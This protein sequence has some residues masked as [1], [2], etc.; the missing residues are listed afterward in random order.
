MGKLIIHYTDN[1]EECGAVLY[2]GEVLQF[3][4]DDGVETVAGAIKELIDLGFIHK[5]DVREIYG[6]EI[7]SYVKEWKKND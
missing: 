5:G 6:G 7:Y 2:N 4:W 1:T 3:S